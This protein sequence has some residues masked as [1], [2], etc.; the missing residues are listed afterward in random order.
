MNERLCAL[1]HK[2][3]FLLFLSLSVVGGASAY[4]D[5]SKAHPGLGG[6][7]NPG[8]GGFGGII[9]ITKETP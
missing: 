6:A 3:C 5:Y 2:E 9:P 1:F 7:P 4:Q 8:G